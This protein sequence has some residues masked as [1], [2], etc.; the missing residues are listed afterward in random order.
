MAI[1]PIANAIRTTEGRIFLMG[2]TRYGRGKRSIFSITLGLGFLL[3]TSGYA[4]DTVGEGTRVSLEYTLTLEDQEVI[5]T[6]VGKDPLVYTHGSREIIPGL[7][8]QLIGL[9][10][11]DTK[12][13]EVAPAEGY[14]EVDPNRVQEVPKEN[15]PEEAWGVGKKLQG[16]GPDGGMMFAEVT[17]VRE[18]TVIVDLNHPLAGKTLFFAVKVLNIEAAEAQKVDM[19][20][21]APAT[22]Q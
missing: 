2:T 1:N 13:V 9:K 16:R 14:G 18:N 11:G 15:V 21:T 10:V 3:A 7:E 12:N 6:N 8:K 19:P 20:G 22:K 5:D 17:E 4:Q